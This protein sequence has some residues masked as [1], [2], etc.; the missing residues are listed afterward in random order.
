[1]REFIDI[2]GQML[3]EKVGF[4]LDQR[5]RQI[6]CL[7]NPT[8]P[9]A[10]AHLKVWD[11]AR[12]MLDEHGNLYMCDRMDAYHYQMAQQLGVDFTNA[13]CFYGFPEY[14]GLDLDP[15]CNNPAFREK[16]ANEQTTIVA[17]K[18]VQRVWG[19]DVTFKSVNSD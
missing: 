18:N 17:N 1:M 4:I 8:K 2:V 14:V 3:S 13:I 6:T 15:Y 5:S 10:Q 12:V 9:E 16:V 11:G 19:V 7:T